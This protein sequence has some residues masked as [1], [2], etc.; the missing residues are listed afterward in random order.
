MAWLFYDFFDHPTIHGPLPEKRWVPSANDKR[1]KVRHSSKVTRSTGGVSAD[2]LN[3]RHAVAYAHWL[4][5][6]D[7]IE[8]PAGLEYVVDWSSVTGP[9]GKLQKR[10]R[11]VEF[12]KRRTTSSGYGRTACTT[13]HWDVVSRIEIPNWDW[14]PAEPVEEIIPE[15]VPVPVAPSLKIPGRILRTSCLV[16][17]MARVPVAPSCAIRLAA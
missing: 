3:A 9:N 17:V 6:R 8:I 14:Q 4:A 10:V 7:A 11:A 16:P 2:D 13:H 12:G 5:R 1:H 15:A